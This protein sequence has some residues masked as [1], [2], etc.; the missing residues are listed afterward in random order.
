MN[1]T[2]VHQRGL[3]LNV[4]KALSFAFFKYNFVIIII[5][6]K[7]FGGLVFLVLVTEIKFQVQTGEV[8]EQSFQCLTK[9]RKSR[10]FFERGSYAVRANASSAQLFDGSC[11]IIRHT[12]PS[13]RKTKVDVGEHVGEQYLLITF[14]HFSQSKRV[15]SIIH[16]C[17]IYQDNISLH[18]K[19][20]DD[21]M[22]STEMM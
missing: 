12:F 9:Q 8:I 16:S 17:G 20:P 7:L 11:I 19:K 22:L 18:S 10:K 13:E 2:K 1:R 15:K 6:Q 4:N 14:D 3:D 5:L 21:V